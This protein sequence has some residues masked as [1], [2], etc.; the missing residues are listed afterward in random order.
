MNPA[1]ENL[2]KNMFLRKKPGSKKSPRTYQL[3]PKVMPEIGEAIAKKAELSAQNK[4]K[5]VR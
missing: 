2:D 3:H 5:V 1:P 4:K